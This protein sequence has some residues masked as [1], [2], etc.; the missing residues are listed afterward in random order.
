[1]KTAD[2]IYEYTLKGATWLARPAIVFYTLP[3]LML[4]LVCGT[5][6]QRYMGLYDAQKMFFSSFIL[7]TGFVPLP[8]GYSLIAVISLCLLVKFLF[9]SQWKLKKAG[10]NL[11]HLGILVLLCG[12]LLTALQAEE[13]YVV[14]PEKGRTTSISDYHQRELLILKNGI[15]HT[16][17]PHQ[18][19]VSGMD[20]QFEGLPFALKVRNH[21]RNCRIFKREEAQE[22][23]GLPFLGMGKFMA[24]EAQAPEKEDEA[25]LYGATLTITGAGEE[26][27]GAYVI[28][29]AMPK[30]ITIEKEGIRYEI[31]YDKEQ[32]SLP[33]T[34]ELVDFQKSVHPGTETP[35]HYHSD[36]MVEDN[37]IRWPVRIEMNKPLR[38]KGYTLFQSSFAR[39]RDETVTIL[40]AVKNKGWLFPYIGVA[41]I[42]IGLF[43]HVIL[44]STGRR[45]RP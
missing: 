24:L 22:N 8:G 28:F 42:T 38:Y 37:S 2:L 33:F 5:V 21:C 4:L 29:E 13:G 19:I 15:I 11:T 23:Y 31:I 43:L 20:F 44:M 17:I 32:R 45:Q 6:A 3:F 10:I 39:N 34:L 25:N 18:N 41:I 9:F 26:F 16:R 30:P 27:D 36:I 35:S 12:G 7:W 40:S 14:I 1:M